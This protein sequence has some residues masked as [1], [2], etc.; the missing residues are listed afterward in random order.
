MTFNVRWVAACLVVAGFAL[1]LSWAALLTGDERDLGA[2]GPYR[3]R[4][5]VSCVCKE[6]K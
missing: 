4:E 6:S 5:T 1:V 2:E 3:R